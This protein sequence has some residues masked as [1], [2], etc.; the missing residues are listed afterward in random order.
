MFVA[1]IGEFVNQAQTNR[2]LARISERQHQLIR[3]DDVRASGI[4]RKALDRRVAAG[5]LSLVDENLYR[6]TSSPATWHQR[7]L[8]AVWTQ[9][10]GALLSHRA[11][12]L[13]H[14][15][16]GIESA[17]FEILVERW[18]RRR[19]R[20]NTVVHETISLTPT[21][22]TVRR[23]IPCTNVVRTI[24]DLAGVVAPL[25]ADQAVEDA[26]RRRLCT[27]EQIADRFVQLARRGR[28]GVAVMRTLLEKRVG[29]T[30]PTKTEFERRVD[31]LA[32][33]AGLPELARQIKV[34]LDGT[35]AYVDLGWPD[36][37][38]GIEC[39]GL[40]DHATNVRLPWD[41]DRQNRLQLRGWLILRFTW[42][43]LTS[44]PDTVID[45]LRDGFALRA[46]LS[47]SGCG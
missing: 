42:H 46:E 3:V 39:D 43:A 11:A 45:Q 10:P 36:R 37:L 2:A 17:P 28:P 27:V 12:A 34:D 26:L 18:A 40:Y 25:R 5:L 6:V 44:T 24:I 16:D 29:A 1:S 41:D 30:V 9:G 32:R 19:R 22:R 13:L 33:V 4:S 14:E 23:A 47:V 20:R 7:A 21:D 15:I 31:E 8:V 35:P 38:L